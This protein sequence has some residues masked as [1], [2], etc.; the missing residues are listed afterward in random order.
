MTSSSPWSVKGIEPKARES[1]KEL[2]R[3]SGMTLGE[4]LSERIREEAAGGATGGGGAAGAPL[5]EALDRL[6]SRIEMAEHR[7]TLAVTGIDQSVRGVLARLEIAERDQVSL[8][9][10]FEG[11]MQDSAEAQAALAERLARVEADAAG[12]RSSEAIKALEGTISR[13]ANQVYDNEGR[14]RETLA[15]LRRDLGALH[16]RLENVEQGPAGTADLVIAKVGERLDQAEARTTAAIRALEGSFAQLDRRMAAAEGRLDDGGEASSANLQQRLGEIAANLSRGVEAARIEMA[17][18]LRASADGRFDRMEKALKEMTAHVESAERRSAEAIDRMGHEVLRVAEAL[19]GKV[20]RIENHSASAIEQVGGEV[21]KVVGSL[22]LRMHRA[23]A[24]QAQ[25]LEKL[26][27]EIGRI[28]ERL[29]ERIGNAE[30]RSAQAID[31]VSEQVSR[32]TERLNQRYERS[33]SDLAERIRQSEER[34]ARLLEE[35]RERIDQRL[36]EQQRRGELPA[37]PAPAAARDVYDEDFLPPPFP[38]ESV[39]AAAEGAPQAVLYPDAAPFGQAFA[40]AGFTPV[41]PDFAPDDLTAA[42]NFPEP[43]SPQS[44]ADFMEDAEPAPLEQVVTLEPQIEEPAFPFQKQSVFALDD[45]QAEADEPVAESA[46]PPAS[47]EQAPR[48]PTTREL[49]EQARAAARAASEGRGRRTSSPLAGDPAVAFQPAYDSRRRHKQRKRSSGPPVAMAA[50]FVGAVALLGGAS[51]LYLN[52][53]ASQRLAGMLHLNGANPAAA[54]SAE[55]ATPQMAMALDPQPIDAAD[56]AQEGPNDLIDPGAI[57]A[58]ETAAPAAGEKPAPAASENAASLYRTGRSRLEGGDKGGLEPLRRAANL[59]SPQAQ[60][61]LGLIYRDGKSGVSKDLTEARR[62]YERA[63]AGGDITAMHAVGLMHFNGEGGPKNLTS[64]A[65]WFRRAA[66]MGS[67]DSQYNLGVLYEEG[68]GVSKNP[69]EAYKWYLLA[70]RGGAADKRAEAKA[71]ADR[72]RGG[73]SPEAQAS[74]ERLASTYTPQAAGSAQVAT[75]DYLSVQKTLGRLGY[76]HGSQDGQASAE[77][78]SAIR[79]YQRDQGLAVSGSLDASTLNR[80]NATGG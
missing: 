75:A 60:A 66:E 50:T 11:A 20:S 6:T 3:R 21:A 65:Q 35:A 39:R 7:S 42:Q 48:A 44:E 26:S 19:N 52:P 43:A 78:R 56:A 53:D 79:D 8:G 71:A 62:W 17:E 9:A 4:W 49:I 37:A 2:A 41:R 16:G 24:V 38:A 15:D 46:P 72:V 34:T 12:P 29:A 55:E 47:P 18:Q 22:D 64:A 10:R 74:A 25:A 63:A 45:F 57:A 77:L 54:P 68:Y 61:Y 67:S 23:E 30:R 13:V 59:G 5:N 70:S 33:S 31:D 69:A 40:P 51:A 32:V 27:G 36:T 14:M 28:S 73:L 58:D 1:A 80:L 76:Y